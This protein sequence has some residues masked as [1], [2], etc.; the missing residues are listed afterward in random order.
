MIL[1]PPVGF[2]DA[3]HIRDVLSL[4]VDPVQVERLTLY[5]D[6]EVAVLVNHTLCLLQILLHSGRVP[7]VHQV[8][9]SVLLAALVL[10]G[11]TLLVF[12]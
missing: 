6:G 10:W 2:S 8:A 1:Y 5:L 7:P 4:G 9:I 3:S 11:E 12:Y